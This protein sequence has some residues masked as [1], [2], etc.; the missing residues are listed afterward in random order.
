MTLDS[1]YLYTL[2]FI[3]GLCFG[4]FLNVVVYR[5]PLKKSLVTP[6]SS[7]PGCSTQ[8]GFVELIPLIGY[9]ILKGKCRNCGMR[10][11]PRYPLVEFLT[12]ILFFAIFYK[13]GFNMSAL[14]YLVLLYILFGVTLIDLDH[15]IVPNTLVAAGLIAAAAMFIPAFLNI[16]LN[17]PEY[18]MPDRPLSDAFFGLLV[19]G[20]IMLLIIL[21]SRGGMGAGDMKLMLMIGCYVGLRGTAVVLMLGFVFGALVG[22]AFMIMKKLTRKDALPFAPYLSLAS[23]INVFWGEQIWSWYINLMR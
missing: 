3:V 21:V 1:A 23:L 17:V 12:G 5:L 20:V 7:C 6:P 22:V 14:F 15:R 4:S 11:S 18:I 13:F 19:G 2:I 8:L 9:L 10:I 16:W